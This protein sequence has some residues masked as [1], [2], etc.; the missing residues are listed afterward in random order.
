MYHVWRAYSTTLERLRSRKTGG[1]TQK[2]PDCFAKLFQTRQ[3]PTLCLFSAGGRATKCSDW[4]AIHF[5]RNADFLVKQ[6]NILL[7]CSGDLTH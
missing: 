4:E 6:Q 7:H 2:E 5:V 1:M 3:R